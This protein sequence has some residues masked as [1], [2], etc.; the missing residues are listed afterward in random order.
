MAVCVGF[1]DEVEGEKRGYEIREKV[2]EGGG[3]C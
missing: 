1:E 3:G 2:S